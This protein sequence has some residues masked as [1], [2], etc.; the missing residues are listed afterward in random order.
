M[1]NCMTI[2]YNIKVDNIIVKLQNDNYS[3]FNSLLYLFIDLHRKNR[4]DLIK[5]IID[6][7]P[8]E[9]IRNTFMW[10]ISMYYPHN[11]YLFYLRKACLPNK[12][13]LDY[14]FIEKK[15]SL[16]HYTSINYNEKELFL[17]DLIDRADFI[18]DSKIFLPK[19]LRDQNL[20]PMNILNLA[21]NDGFNVLMMAIRYNKT[22]II[23]I[24]Q[25][26]RHMKLTENQKLIINKQLNRQKRDIQTSIILNSNFFSIM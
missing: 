2:Y 22:E 17:V 12:N 26:E 9:K 16:T 10:W 25:N 19:L 5:K 6:N 1:G 8:E 20:T 23:N 14:I 11:A 24:L 4:M 15:Y 3:K 21:N 18:P 7:S 13:I